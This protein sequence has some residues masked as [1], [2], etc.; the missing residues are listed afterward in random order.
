MLY[1]ERASLSILTVVI[2]MACRPPAASAFVDD[3][4]RTP[5]VR[6][7]EKVSPSVVNISMQADVPERS[8]PFSMFE[9]DPFFDSFFRDFFEHSPRRQN[10]ATSLGS[11]VIINAQGYVVTNWHVVEKA[12]S[13]TVTTEDEKT[14]EA[15]LVGADPQSDL[16]VLKVA[17][18]NPFNPIPLGDSDQLLIGETVIAIGNPFGLSH[19]VTT[20]VISALNR[21]IRTGETVYENFIQTDASIN[22]GNSGGPLLDI[23]GRLIGIN[24]AIYGR[25]EGIGFAIPVNTARRIVDELLLHG[26][27]RPAFIGVS[28][29]ELTPDLAD[30]LGHSAAGVLVSDV[31]SGSPAARAGVENAD[32]ITH[33]DNHTIKSADGFRRTISGYTPRDTLRLSIVRSKKNLSLSVQAAEFPPRHIE[34]LISSVL[35]L[36]LAQNTPALARRHGLQAAAGVLITDVSRAGTAY[37]KGLRPGD[38]IL[39]VHNSDVQSVEEL[40]QEMLQHVYRDSIVLLVQRGRYGYYVTCNF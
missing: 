16:A 8:S 38:I 36:T 6:A 35:G 11:G 9:G 1:P 26:R 12:S 39:R 17:A 28:V 29:Q 5:V 37:A 4:R 31:A 21:S 10:V 27:V 32:I 19:T 34:H 33:I 3:M 18:D 7:V 14:F 22:P 20:G 13:L 40:L 23:H 25:A 2:I 30:H 24:T 15:R